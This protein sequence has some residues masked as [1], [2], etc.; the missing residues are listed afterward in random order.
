M[1]SAVTFKGFAAEPVVRD[2]VTRSANAA[3]NQDLKFI[4]FPPSVI[5]AFLFFHA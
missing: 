4:P 5:R 3:L 2:N 1:A